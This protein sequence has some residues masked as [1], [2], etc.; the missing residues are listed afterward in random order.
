MIEFIV[1]GI[2]TF[3]IVSLS[4]FLIHYKALNY[5]QINTIRLGFPFKYIIQHTSLTP[6]ISDFPINL[7]FMS[8]MENPTEFIL[9]NY[10]FSLLMIWIILFVLFRFAK[11]IWYKIHS[12]V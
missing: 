2:I 5:D 12:T 10:I 1:I 9:Q 7:T 11:Y 6:N 3:V 8:P 4:P